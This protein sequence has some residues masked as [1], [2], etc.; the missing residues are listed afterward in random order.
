MPEKSKLS[1]E[2]MRTKLSKFK[3]RVLSTKHKSLETSL[4][5]FSE[6]TD[7]AVDSLKKEG[8]NK[9]AEKLSKEA[10][11]V[12]EDPSKVG[13]FN[14]KVEGLKLPEKIKNKLMTFSVRVEDAFSSLKDAFIDRVDS[15]KKKHEE[16]KTKS[17][18]LNYFK[19]INGIAKRSSQLPFFKP[20]LQGEG[21]QVDESNIA[22]IILEKVK[23]SKL[24]TSL[25][26]SVRK[27]VNEMLKTT[28]KVNKELEKEVKHCNGLSDKE[29]I[30]E[31]LS[32][33]QAL[34]MGELIEVL[35]LPIQDKYKSR[36]LGKIANNPECKKLIE[37][38]VES[39]E[40]NKNKAE[41]YYR[42]IV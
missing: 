29:K 16:S 31:Y 40:N 32:D 34:H 36:S 13:E 25:S 10:T 33:K 24:N 37:D 27:W 42:E 21:F 11:A 3:D 28:K 6:A 35:K 12:Q 14:K 26:P 8:K 2:S 17:K 18:F 4:E 39:L 20:L 30:I 23:A 22:K 7:E 38:T 41:S 19:A 5:Q 9:E 15:I 1:W